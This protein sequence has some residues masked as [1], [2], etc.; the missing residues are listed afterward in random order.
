GGSAPAAPAV[1]TTSPGQR[2]ERAWAMSTARRGGAWGRLH[3]TDTISELGLPPRFCLP[4][5]ADT[6]KSPI[7]KSRSGVDAINAWAWAR[8]GTP[9]SSRN[10]RTE[11]ARSRR[12]RDV[13][14]VPR[15][16]DSEIRRIVIAKVG[17]AGCLIP[18]RP[19]SRLIHRAAACSKCPNW[20]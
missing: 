11:T 9:L 17:V 15:P 16:L 14:R 8:L 20:L 5:D 1:P 19:P 3:D 7:V 18:E 4:T 12:R 13:R 2:R 10:A 6:N